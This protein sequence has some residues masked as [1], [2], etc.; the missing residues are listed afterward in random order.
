MGFLLEIFF[1]SNSFSVLTGLLCKTLDTHND[2]FLLAT[3]LILSYSTF[4]SYLS[5]SSTYNLNFFSSRLFSLIFNFH[6]IT[7]SLSVLV[8]GHVF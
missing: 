2:F 4:F 3:I 5:P 7:F 6:D 1:S 8:L